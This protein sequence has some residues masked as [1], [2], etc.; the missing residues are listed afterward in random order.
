MNIKIKLLKE[1][2]LADKSAK[3]YLLISV[4]FSLIDV[5]TKVLVPYIFENYIDMIVKGSEGEDFFLST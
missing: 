4:I 1:I 5:A 3:I 2:I